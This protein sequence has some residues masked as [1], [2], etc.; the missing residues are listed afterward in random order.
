LKWENSTGSF[1]MKRRSHTGIY[2]SLTKVART[3]DIP[4]AGRCQN[5]R[6]AMYVNVY[7]EQNNGRTPYE[8]T[9]PKD[10]PVDA[11]WSVTVYNKDGFITPN[12]LNAYSVNDVTGKKNAD[13]SV[14]IH[15]GGGPNQSNYLPITDGWNYIVRLYLPQWQIIEGNWTPPAP[16]PVE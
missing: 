12:K 2:A 11:F 1:L 14:T 8:L 16:Q 3:V 9:M 6:C 7:P 13:G 10:V 5:P 15:F 4:R